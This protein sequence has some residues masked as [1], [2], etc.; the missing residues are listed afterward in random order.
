MQKDL[1]FYC[2]TH[3]ASAS[4]VVY[5]IIIYEAHDYIETEEVISWL[6]R[7]WTLWRCCKQY[8]NHNHSW[9]AWW[10]EWYEEFDDEIYF[11]I[12]EILDQ[13]VDDYPTYEW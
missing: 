8:M 9:P 10:W 5:R 6:D 2:W 7:W 4:S 1:V 12:T 3:E 11:D 13:Y